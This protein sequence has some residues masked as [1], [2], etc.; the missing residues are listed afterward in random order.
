MG[1]IKNQRRLQTD[2]HA[3]GG[4][5]EYERP[6]LGKQVL[7]VNRTA[8][9]HSFPHI[10]RDQASKLERGDVNDLM[11]S[12]HG[13]N[14]IG[15]QALSQCRSAPAASLYKDGERFKN[16]KG[17]RGRKTKGGSEGPDFILPPSSLGAQLASDKRS[18]TGY[19]FAPIPKRDYNIEAALITPGPG[20]YPAP[21]IPEPT[22]HLRTAPAPVSISEMFRLFGFG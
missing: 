15:K 22:I 4:L 9:T 7:S 5:G 14:A 8:A 19:S 6:S 3:A 2:L 16:S 1:K 20:M 21:G 10:E 18:N 12:S 11:Y 17:K 13:R